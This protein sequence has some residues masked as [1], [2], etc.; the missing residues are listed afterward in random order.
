MRSSPPTHAFYVKPD[1]PY[2]TVTTLRTILKKWQSTKQVLIDDS[3]K[4]AVLQG[5]DV[6]DSILHNYLS[7]Q[8][9][10]VHPSSPSFPVRRSDSPPFF[11]PRR[12]DDG[13]LPTP[14]H[15]SPFSYFS[16]ALGLLSQA[17]GFSLRRLRS[18]LK[19]SS[20]P[21]SR[22]TPT[23]LEV[24]PLSFPPLP[25]PIASPHLSPAPS[26]LPFLSPLLLTFL[27]LHMCRLHTCIDKVTVRP[28][29]GLST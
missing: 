20:T 12:S 2:S 18:P 4:E 17:L 22:S 11:T 5:Q 7:P 3:C 27:S 19:T 24:Y 9:L 10:P 29:S 13:I 15:S 26:S 28:L 23:T 14:L 6:V 1:C 8:I 21:I 16:Q 25:F